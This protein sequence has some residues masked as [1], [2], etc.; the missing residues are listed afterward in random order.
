[1]PGSVPDKQ[2]TDSLMLLKR[3]S[4]LIKEKGLYLQP[5]PVSLCES[6]WRGV[7]CCG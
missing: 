3:R 5:S 6:R 1:M 2:V 7:S 4:N